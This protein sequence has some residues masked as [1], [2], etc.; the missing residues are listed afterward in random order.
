MLERIFDAVDLSKKI[1][2]GFTVL[3]EL[4][5]RTVPRIRKLIPV[6]KEMNPESRG[7]S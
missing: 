7:F 6:G 1:F 5:N 2:K 4:K 3:S